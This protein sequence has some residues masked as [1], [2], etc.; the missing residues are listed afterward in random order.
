MTRAKGRAPLRLG[1]SAC[2]LG[3][4]VRWDGGDKRAPFLTDT[5]GR[6]VEWVAV[7]PEVELGLGVPR[8]PIRLE[9]DAV[10]SRLVAV[11]S[12]RDLTADMEALARRWVATL[13][14]LGIAG[15]VLKSESPSCGLSRVRVHGDGGRDSRTGVGTFARVLTERMRLLPVEEEERLRDPELRRRFL[16][17]CRAYRRRTGGAA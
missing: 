1:I 9:G 10:A 11:E 17:R 16:A 12:R 2:L 3:E 7:C 13:A 8:E 14:R 6:S 15:F 4:A 5:L